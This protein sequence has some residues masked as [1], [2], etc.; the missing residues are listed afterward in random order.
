ME[1]L[2]GK[3]ILEVIVELSG[4]E[5][6]YIDRMLNKEHKVKIGDF[7]FAYFDKRMRCD[8]KYHILKHNSPVSLDNLDFIGQEKEI[9]VGLTSLVNIIEI[10]GASATG[11]IPAHIPF[12]DIDLN[13][14]GLSQNERIMS[15]VKKLIK[16]H[17][18]INKG[19]FLNSKSK[20]NMHFI[21]MDKVF[22]HDDFITF[23][24]LCLTIG[25]QEGEN[26]RYNIVDYRHVGHSLTPQNCLS[27]LKKSKYCNIDRFSTL[28]VNTKIEGSYSKVIDVLQ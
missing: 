11:Y 25:Y 3:S 4:H 26:K 22:C 23:L 27:K 21:G 18:E 24:G 1:H 2:I 9:G 17:T 7:C 15:F 19:V 13:K 14:I 20:D 10:D 16:E 28:S 12:M 6:S 5:F 8:T